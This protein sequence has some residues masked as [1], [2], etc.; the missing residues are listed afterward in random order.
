MNGI[1][2]SHHNGI[3]DWNKVVK[4]VFKPEF[5]YIKTTEG[6]GYVDPKF[7][8]NAQGA[9]KTSIKIGYYHFAS[10]NSSDITN[11]AIKEAE[12]FVLTI[13]KAPA[14]TMPL[15]L[16]IETNKA[17]LSKEQVVLWVKTF[18]AELA[19]LGYTDVM[20]YSYTPFLNENLP[21]NHGLGTYK[22]W[23]ADY[24]PPLILPKGWDKAYIWQYSAKGK[25]SGIATN[26]DL[27][28]TI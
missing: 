3:I 24:G 16:D 26:V 5:V 4:D 27:N 2:V 22:L 9:A 18:F 11:D 17:K 6:T 15:V 8:V 25:I 13:K 10:L 12:A 21:I 20:L 19:K 28:K 1:D 14:P 23:I 7:L